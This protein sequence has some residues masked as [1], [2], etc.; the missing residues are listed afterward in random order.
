MIVLK[1]FLYLG[2]SFVCQQEKGSVALI[3]K[4]SQVTLYVN[5]CKSPFILERSFKNNDKN[6]IKVQ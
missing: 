2:R 5:C 3:A 4:T 1:K 6:F